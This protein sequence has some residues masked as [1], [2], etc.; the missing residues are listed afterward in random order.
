[1]PGD[2]LLIGLDTGRVSFGEG[3]AAPALGITPIDVSGAGYAGGNLA[4]H[5]K[6]A[7]EDF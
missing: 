2:P 7:V 5:V 1:V 4:L 6:P 3:S